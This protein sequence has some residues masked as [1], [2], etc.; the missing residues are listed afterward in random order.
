MRR[1]TGSGI[2]KEAVRGKKRRRGGSFCSSVGSV[3]ERITYIQFDHCPCAKAK[4]LPTIIPCKSVHVSIAPGGHAR[5]G[6]TA[7]E[8]D[9]MSFTVYRKKEKCIIRIARWTHADPERGRERREESPARIIHASIY[10]S[11]AWANQTDIIDLT[12]DLEIRKIADAEG[13]EPI[14]IVNTGRPSPVISPT[15]NPLPSP[16]R[17]T[18]S[19]SFVHRLDVSRQR[20]GRRL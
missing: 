2:A 7:I 8:G 15:P 18:V 3:T 1:T 11:E 9:E 16:P 19:S 13:L 4:D 5:L 17:C 20:Y 6:T 12:C 14:I 10:R